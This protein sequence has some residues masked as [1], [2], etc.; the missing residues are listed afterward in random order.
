MH[1][2]LSTCIATIQITH[3]HE[4]DDSPKQDDRFFPDPDDPPLS[5][6]S[7]KKG[8]WDGLVIPDC[9]LRPMSI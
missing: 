8:L 5:E 4:G 3:L 7:A 2:T 6:V 9:L 1:Q